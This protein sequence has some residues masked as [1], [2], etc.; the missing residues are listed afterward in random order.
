MRQGKEIL[1]GK[2]SSPKRKTKRKK[3]FMSHFPQPPRKYIENF[4]LI[5]VFTVSYCSFFSLYVYWGGG[6]CSSAAHMCSNECPC[7]LIL[8]FVYLGLDFQSLTKAQPPRTK[9]SKNTCSCAFSY[10]LI[11]FF[12]FKF[13]SCQIFFFGKQRVDIFLKERDGGIFC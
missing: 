11:F 10:F 6:G 13:Y 3:G 2:L 9:S 4:V 7:L 1:S 5:F 12:F 8:F